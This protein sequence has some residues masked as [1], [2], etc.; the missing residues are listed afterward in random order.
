RFRPSFRYSSTYSS[1]NIRRTLDASRDGKTRSL[2]RVALGND[3]TIVSSLEAVL[4][5]SLI[6]RTVIPGLGRFVAGKFQDNN[7]LAVRPFQ[8]LGS[9]V[10]GKK[11]CGMIL[12]TRWS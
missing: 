11:F 3:A 7:L 12:E 5:C 2:G 8:H 6:L 1:S 10:D 9:A 4:A